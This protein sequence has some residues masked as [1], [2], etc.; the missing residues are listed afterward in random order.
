MA[1]HWPRTV[2]PFRAELISLCCVVKPWR[3]LFVYSNLVPRGAKL[4]SAYSGA[5]LVA[6]YNRAARRLV[7]AFCVFLLAATNKTATEDP[8][9]TCSG[10]SARRTQITPTTAAGQHSARSLS[11]ST[12]P[13]GSGTWATMIDESINTPTAKKKTTPTGLHSAHLGIEL[14]VQQEVEPRVY[15]QPRLLDQAFGGTL[16]QVPAELAVA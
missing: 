1:A 9:A 2:K 15:G 8:T 12:N 3:F 14:P 4:L 16:H 7:S 6:A 5:R 10:H 13:P 11:W